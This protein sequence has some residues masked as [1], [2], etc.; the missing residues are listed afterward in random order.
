MIQLIFLGTG[1][2]QGIPV[3][4]ST[5]PV[6]LSSNTKD[7]RLRSSVLLSWNN[8]NY[9]IDCGPDFRQQILNN[10]IKTLDGILFTHAHADHTAG[11]DDIRPF[12]FRQGLIDIYSTSAVLKNLKKRFDYIIDDKNKYPG[13]PSV[14]LNIFNENKK[15]ELSDKWVVPIK[16]MHNDIPVTG[17]RIENIAYMTDIKFID[18]KSKSKLRNLD[19]LVLNCL[20]IETHQSHLNLEE[21]IELVN[22]LKPKKAYFTHI[23]NLLGLHDE[24]SKKLP[25]NIY[26]AYD[27]LCLKCK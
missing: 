25:K 22:E 11:F 12:Y 27:N 24:V 18:S 2:S 8:K 7:K 5:N 16:A 6:C 10:Q 23:S 1:T 26:L 20:R 13:A 17:F 4:G 21:A 9:V 3:I 19:I 14:R 15:F